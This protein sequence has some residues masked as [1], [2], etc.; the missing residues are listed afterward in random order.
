MLSKKAIFT[1]LIIVFSITLGLTILLK[2]LGFTLVGKSAFMSQMVIVGAMFIPALGAVLTQVLI[3]RKPLKELG[4]QLG[5]VS[6]YGK[7]YLVI[8]GIFILNYGITWAF[9]ERPDPSLQSFI[10]MAGIPGPLPV[11]AW[12]MI[13]IFIFVTLFVTPFFNLLP[14]LGEEIGWRGFLLPALEP[15]GKIPAVLLSAMIWALWHTPLIL[16]LGFGYGDQAWPGV[17]LHFV[18]VTSLGIWFGYIWF[19]TRSTILAGFMHATFNANAYGI[20]ALLFVSENRLAVGPG[21]VTG[22]ALCALLAVFVILRMRRE[23]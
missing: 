6:M 20:W 18:M 13:A 2:I 23:V 17:L 8:L 14:S 19:K 7:T 15:L 10:D 9:I 16:I 22:A 5:P 12:A 21:S 4:F 3:V 1:F 11:P